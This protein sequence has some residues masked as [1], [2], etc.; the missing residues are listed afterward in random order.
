MRKVSLLFAQKVIHLSIECYFPLE[1]IQRNAIELIENFS[2]LHSLKIYHFL[3]LDNALDCV[4]N[5]LNTIEIICNPFW[6]SDRFNDRDVRAMVDLIRRN[7]TTIQQLF[8]NDYLIS[9]ELFSFI[10]KNLNLKELSFNC[11]QLSMK[12]IVKVLS[13]YQKKLSFLGLTKLSEEKTIETIDNKFYCFNVKYLRLISCSFRVKSFLDF[14]KIFKNLEKFEFSGLLFECECN[15]TID[16]FG[17][18]TCV[19]KCF[20]GLSKSRNLK[21]FESQNIFI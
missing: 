17:C 5:R 18:Q 2:N 14:I 15:D 10:C 4:S 13:I 12:S 19:Q 9:E 3:P 7:K 6:F 11:I 1:S 20:D 16:T 8:I 21:K